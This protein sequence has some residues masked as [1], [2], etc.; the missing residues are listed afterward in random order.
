MEIDELKDHRYIR[1]DNEGCGVVSKD[2]G[3]AEINEDIVLDKPPR[4]SE[5]T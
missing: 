5:I 4:K 3:R 2:R 1:V